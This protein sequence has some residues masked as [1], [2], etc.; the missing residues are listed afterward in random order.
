MKKILLFSLVFLASFGAQAQCGAT[1]VGGNV[2][3]DIPVNGSVLNTY[4][5][6]D[7]N[8]QGRQGITVTV[9]DNNQATQTTVTDVNGDWSVSSP[10]FPV[11]VEFS[12]A[13]SWLK[14][15]PFG[16][17][18]NASVRAVSSSDCAVNLAVSD[19]NNYSH[20]AAPDYVSNIRIS[21][22][23]IGNT[24]SS[25]ETVHYNDTGLNSNFQTYDGTQGIGP[26]PTTDATVAEIG[27]VWG[28]AYQP[29]KERMFLT[30]VLWRHVGFAAGKGPGD[31]FLVDYSGA[32]GSV[33]GSVNLQGVV[34]QNGGA[35][36]DFGT[37]CRGGG[38]ENDPGQTGILADYTL[39]DDPLSPSVDLDAFAKAGRM[40]Y[41]GIS[42][43][44]GTDKIWTVNLFQKGIIE[45]DASGDM[46][47]LAGT[48]KQYLIESLPNVPSCVGGNLMPWALKVHEGKGYLGCLC[49]GLNSQLTSDMDAYVLSFDL[50]NPAAGFTS[51]ISIPLDYNKNGLDWNAWSDVDVSTGSNWTRYLQP[52]LSDIEFDELNN[53]YLSF[54]DRWGIQAGYRQ[55]SPVSGNTTTTEKAQSAGE[56]FKV[57]F[58]SGTYELEGT[59]AC[60]INY[61]TNGEF[62]NDKA[63]DNFSDGAG[64]ALAML[65]GSNQL[66]VQLVDPHP[67]G[68]VGQTYWSTQ[69]VTTLSTINGSVE[70]W[71]SNIYSSTLSYNG[72]GVG[73]G[74]VEL[75]TEPAPIEVGNLVWNDAN[76]N[77]IQDPSEAGVSG[78]MIQLLDNNDVVMGSATTDAN[79]HYIFSS[80]LGTNTASRIFNI[81]N[82][83][84][85]A[86]YKLVILNAVGGS[87]Q[88]VLSGLQLSQNDSG[89]GANTDLND[90]DATLTGNNAEIG[91]TPSGIPSVGTNN[92]SFDFGFTLLPQI[93]W[94]DLPD[95]SAGTGVGDYQTLSANNG[96][97]HTLGS[98]IWLGAA[99]TGEADGLQ[100]SG[101]NGDADDGIT[102]SNNLHAYPGTILNFPIS[103]NNTT[104][105]TGHMEGWID[106]NG[107]GSFE[108][109]E[110]A[111]DYS[112]AV[113][114][115][116]YL[117]ILV[118]SDAVTDQ[119]IG[120]RL[121]ISTTNNMTPLGAMSDGEVEDYMI[122]VTC[123]T[124]V[125]LPI[126]TN[127]H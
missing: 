75:L 64:G 38:C 93:D 51:V 3:I 97:S 126:T 43:D 104:G 17:G 110:K 52:I 70:N 7:A 25:L 82:L 37:V 5:V 88:A 2:F 114:F 26:N 99:V 72:K 109:S 1:D 115:P 10:V 45:I 14:E 27:S 41:G 40:S 68:M 66:L 101:A 80:G 125:C 71:Y 105:S 54:I 78:V 119:P 127:K 13:E 92:H 76:G 96:P 30:S 35:A 91:V 79:G 122:V 106:W 102:G 20:T 16:N 103:T 84:H 95:I 24:L 31:I 57:C 34:P 18:L 120:F 108:P 113:I 15:S 58:N 33:S 81:T 21:G 19:V 89:Q 90:S 36:L 98:N 107:N 49:D 6:K 46:N 87:Q 86:N 83:I 124:S 60:P 50:A 53:M 69:G 116:S 9:I 11:R 28:K 22:S 44:A 56:L 74:D 12:W 8:E 39:P 117:S 42:F 59:G 61:P 55:H 100:D 94:G 32:S 77:G 121:R 118:P 123:P 47:S 23:S 65:Q 48:A 85:Q 29:S 67:E 111:V 62:F 73:M 63:G 4:G 112:D